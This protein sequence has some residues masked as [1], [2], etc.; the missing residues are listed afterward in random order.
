V[1]VSGDNW[2]SLNA[3]VSGVTGTPAYLT[4]NRP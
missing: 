4:I 3:S 2:A 1:W